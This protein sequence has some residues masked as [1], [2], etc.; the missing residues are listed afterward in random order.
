M[1]IELD[2]LQK[3]NLMLDD[4]L[5]SLREKLANT[6][7]SLHIY[8]RKYKETLVVIK[9]VKTDIYLASGYV[10]NYKDLKDSIKVRSK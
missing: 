7:K 8:K 5:N 1:E 4:N 2:D 9:K 3:M 10:Q 6:Y